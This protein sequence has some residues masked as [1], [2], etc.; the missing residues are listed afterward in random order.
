MPEAYEAELAD[1]VPAEAIAFFSFKDLGAALE[2]YGNLLGLGDVASL[3]AGETAVYLSPGGGA[4]LLTEVEDEAA[5]LETV[6]A[7]IGLA[8]KDVPIAFDAFD[9]LLA[10]SSSEQELAALRGDGP[11]LGQDD[12]FE[13]ALA[14]A[15][16]PDET[17]G[18][19]YVDVESAAPLFLEKAAQE[20][21]YLE[22]LGSAVFWGEASDDEQRFSLFLGID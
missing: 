20:D 22:P 9:G 13:E 4:T 21:E 3:L 17:T 6:E 10:V 18:F 15:G 12:R 7:L 16:M 2:R 11:R 1:E 19:G 5:A 14:A 8:G